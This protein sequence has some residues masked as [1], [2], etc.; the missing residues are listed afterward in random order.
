M[1]TEKLSLKFTARNVDA[2]EQATGQ[3]IE[4]AVASTTVRNITLLLK[5]ALV[6]ENTQQAGV[7]TTVAQDKL[8]N[9]LDNGRDRYDIILDIMEALIQA[10]FLPKSVDT[11]SIRKR[12]DKTGTFEQN[13]S[14]NYGI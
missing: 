3:A 7:S 2:I 14:V 1:D 4:H 8:Q 5:H 12:K 13:G 6:D 9:Q 11:E 10:G